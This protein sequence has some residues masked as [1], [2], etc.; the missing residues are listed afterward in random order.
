MDK[1][2]KI[3]ENNGKQVV[4][5]RELYE[6]L[7]LDTG[8]YNRWVK[9]NI[10]NSEF[11]VENEDWGILFLKTSNRRRGQPSQ[12]YALSLDFAKRLAMMARTEAGERIR[13]YFLDCERKVVSKAVSPAEALLQSVQ[14]LVEQERRLSKVETEVKEIAAKAITSPQ[15]YFAISGYARLVNIPIDLQTAAKIGF[16]AKAKCKSLGIRLGNVYDPRFGRVNTYPKSILE[17]VFN[18]FFVLS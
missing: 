18:D 6:G 1:L 3:I 11:S 9:K 5:A 4:S 8:N 17:V 10:T 14:M 16:K 2:P 7:G 13:Q 15:D 12:D